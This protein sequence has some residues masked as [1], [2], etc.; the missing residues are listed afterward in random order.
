MNTA[1]FYEAKKAFDEAS[2]KFFLERAAFF[3]SCPQRA[4]VEIS[5]HTGQVGN[6]YRLARLECG[7]VVDPDSP[8]FD[9]VGVKSY[10][11]RTS[12]YN[13]ITIGCEQCKKNEENITRLDEF[14]KTG[15][16]SHVTRR[17]LTAS[18]TGAWMSFCVYRR[19]PSSPTGCRLEMS[20][21]C[22]PE[23]EAELRKRDLRACAPNQRV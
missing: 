9:R 15:E 4:V 5:E 20:I 7:H 3:R 16:L 19:D 14:L 2:H 8:L 22:T 1:N 18:G 13:L 23:V 6:K 21:E 10:D 11:M 12:T 17:D